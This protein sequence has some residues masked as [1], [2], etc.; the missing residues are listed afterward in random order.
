MN[1]II[2]ELN[3]AV[4]FWLNWFLISRHCNENTLSGK[5]IEI[6][7]HLL[8][9][10]PYFWG[11]A[12]PFGVKLSVSMYVGSAHVFFHF[13]LS[14]VISPS[15]IIFQ[16]IITW[17]WNLFFCQFNNLNLYQRADS[18]RVN[19]SNYT[20]RN[21]KQKDFNSNMI[22]AICLCGLLFTASSTCQFTWFDI[23]KH[24]VRKHFLADL[25]N[26]HYIFSL[27]CNWYGNE[28]ETG[29]NMIHRKGVC[30]A[31]ERCNICIDVTKAQGRKIA[32]EPWHYNLI[33]FLWHKHP[34]K[35]L[36]VVIFLSSS[37]KYKW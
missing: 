18:A 9:L 20:N 17:W 33:A 37:S 8:V 24:T 30:E 15:H 10:I 21:F 4:I 23:R 11:S 3:D 27:Q 26:K 2:N 6:T 34:Q 31:T 5:I 32:R 14:A 35:P 22:I 36:T 29:C 19:N 28:C 12:Y 25:M 13:P 16:T 7:R 1:E